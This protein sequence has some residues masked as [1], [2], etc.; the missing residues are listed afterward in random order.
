MPEPP[1]ETPKAKETPKE[2]EKEKSEESKDSTSWL[3][4]GSIGF[5]VV[6]VLVIFTSRM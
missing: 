3:L 5:A 1:V 6:A 4:A 2:T